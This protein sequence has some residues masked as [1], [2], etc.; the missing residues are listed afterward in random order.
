MTPH[1]RLDLFSLLTG[2]AFVLSALA[3]AVFDLDTIRDQVHVVWPLT[4]VGLG[5]GL[6]LTARRRT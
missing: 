3:F 2:V 1:R 4:L 5:A 6:V